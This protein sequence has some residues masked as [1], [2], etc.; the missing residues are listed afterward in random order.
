[1]PAREGVRGED[2][3]SIILS[4]QAQVSRLFM[5]F[6][7]HLTAKNYSE[8]H[9]ICK[10]VFDLFLSYAGVFFLLPLWIIFGFAIWLEDGLPIFY[11]QARVGKKARTFYAIK[12][13]T[14]YCNKRSSVIA[15]FLRRTALDESPQL[16]NIIKGQMS[17]V[18]PRPL[19][20]EDINEKEKLHLRASV[21]PGLTGLAQVF[22]PKDAPFKEK[23][24]YDLLYIETRSMPL[25]LWLILRSFF[26]SFKRKWDIIK[27]KPD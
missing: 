19:V 4:L 18:G 7:Y 22:A 5:F 21:C 17:F 10:K 1:M 3:R 8:A 16:I 6:Y 20:S 13:R 15:R 24:K 25:D 23:L 27:V 26:V 11:I 14:I 12:F 9:R 2:L